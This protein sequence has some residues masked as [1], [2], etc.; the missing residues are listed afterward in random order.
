[1]RKHGR[2]VFFFGK[3]ALNFP[4]IGEKRLGLGL[5]ICLLCCVSFCDGPS[6]QSV[7]PNARH[8]K[9]IEIYIVPFITVETADREKDE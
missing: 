4:V 3:K 6:S 1:M 7:L 5:N 9:W 8:V 2:N